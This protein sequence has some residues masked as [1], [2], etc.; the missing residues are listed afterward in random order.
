MWNSHTATLLALR[1]FIHTVCSRSKNLFI[2]V[3]LAL[4]AQGFALQT[5]F[6]FTANSYLESPLLTF[7]QNNLD[8]NIS[9]WSGNSQAINPALISSANGLGVSNT[10]ET[11]DEPYSALDNYEGQDMLLFEFSTAV[12]LT[13]LSLK[14]IYTGPLGSRDADISILAY[15]GSG[16]PDTFNS[17]WQTILNDGWQSIL[18]ADIPNTSDYLLPQ[19]TA[20][21][22]WLV[23]AWNEVFGSTRATQYATASNP[24]WDYFSLADISVTYTQRATKNP[25]SVS[26]PP[27]TGFYIVLAC[28]AIAIRRQSR[29]KAGYH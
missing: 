4:P 28:V 20:S 14:K 15:T 26:A 1:N 13:S 10:N 21:N 2:P 25:I 18:N 7:S 16:Q 19:T 22:Y 9:G 29:L 12:S 27:L 23:G 24:S 11:S 5:T 3:A 17:G 8:V 6:D